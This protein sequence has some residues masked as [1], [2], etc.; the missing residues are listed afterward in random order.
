MIAIWRTL[1]ED[2]SMG[3]M[4]FVPDGQITYKEDGR[5]SYTT[6]PVAWNDLLGARIDLATLDW[7]Q[8][9]EGESGPSLDAPPDEPLPSQNSYG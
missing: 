6:T 2:G 1:G 4:S 8:P 5:L 9:M 3:I 7:D